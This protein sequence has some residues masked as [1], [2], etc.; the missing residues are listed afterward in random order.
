MIDNPRP[1]RAEVN[2]IANAVLDGAD[3]VMLSAESAS[4]KYPELSVQTM[5]ATI[6]EIEKNIDEKKLYYRHHTRVAEPS[7]NSKNK[8]NDNVVMTA[9]RLAR[10]L[11]VKAL[12][13]ITTSGYTAFRLS[14]HRPKAEVFIFTPNLQLLTQ[15]S[16]YWGVRA[17]YLPESHKKSVDQ[18]V[19]EVRDFL[20]NQGELTKG[21]AFINTLSMPLQKSSR[22][23]TIKFSKVE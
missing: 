22:T 12:I 8:E 4:G 15:L 6:L 7:Y 18:V 16:L 1:T 9:C 13:G 23:N 19:D 2:D 21:D 5:T 3:A 11:H 10:D 17:Y 20:V 14:H